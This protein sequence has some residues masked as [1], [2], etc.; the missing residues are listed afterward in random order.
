MP[1]DVRIQ[2]L[3]VA[4]RGIPDDW[5]REE[6][7]PFFERVLRANGGQPFTGSWR[8]ATRLLE[9]PSER[10]APIADYLRAPEGEQA[11]TP[12]GPNQPPP[13]TVSPT[14][15]AP[16]AQPMGPPSPPARD[17]GV[18]GLKED[19]QAVQEADRRNRLPDAWEET[20]GAVNQIV[21]A[22]TR[23]LAPATAG[24]AGGFAVAGPPGAFV[25]AMAVPAAD[26]VVSGINALFGTQW[27]TPSEAIKDL[28]TRTGAVDVPEEEVY[29]MFETAVQMTAQAGAATGL[30]SNLANAPGATAPGFQ[31]RILTDPTTAQGIGSAPITAPRTIAQGMGTGLAGQMAGAGTGTVVEQGISNAAPDSGLA[32]TG[33]MVAG[34]VVD[35]LTG[36]VVDNMQLRNRAANT[37]LD[38]NI[39]RQ[40]DAAEQFGRPLRPDEAL[41]NPLNDPSVRELTDVA[42]RAGTAEGSG[43][44]LQARVRHARETGQRIAD[45]FGVTY[46]DMGGVNDVT[47]EVMRIFNE[48]RGG[49]LSQLWNTKTE[50]I[51]TL[52]NPDMPV[53]TSAT[54][55]LIRGMQE[56][57]AR[58]SGEIFGTEGTK[59]GAIAADLENKSLEDI[60]V[61]RRAIWNMKDDPMMTPGAR[62]EFDKAINEIYDSL[63][64]DMGGHIEELG[65]RAFTSADGDFDA[66]E[67]DA[68]M[69]G[70][71]LRD[72][73]NDTDEGLTNLMKDLRNRDI[74]EMLDEAGNMPIELQSIEAIQGL[75]KPSADPAPYRQM[76]TRLSPEGRDLSVTAIYGNMMEEAGTTLTSPTGLAQIMRRYEPMLQAAAEVSGKPEIYTRA[77]DYV[78][79]VQQV[80]DWV[81]G[82]VGSGLTSNR[83]SMGDN[84]TGG[85][86]LSQ[87]SRQAGLAGAW[88]IGDI[89]KNG[90]GRLAQQFNKPENLARVTNLRNMTTGSVPWVN[91]TMA[92]FRDIYREVIDTELAPEEEE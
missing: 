12:T 65:A 79:Y 91:T 18:F 64:N 55:E 21:S 42:R 4:I 85:I 80:V 72:I 70:R 57:F 88:L 19:V 56:R 13:A 3:G 6:A 31:S 14:L 8:E 60:E 36:G 9:S 23:G 47:P 5:T 62:S 74:V 7:Y 48:T 20:K 89:L 51:A 87:G 45:E 46:T 37:P 90:A 22:A 40:A 2:E 39:Q 63:R 43:D 69:R 53:D 73:W 68:R 38:A 28:L 35:M 24:A 52:S 10:S 76:Y 50:L 30:A 34:T 59:L 41:G 1:K 33:A 84:P 66:M 77:R 29:R 49:E 25:G 32:Q 26:L 58:L 83:L 71:E 86:M 16:E 78:E 82:F 67:A 15:Q 17:P 75:H 61:L 27:A 11:P 92:L 54:R 81:E 44:I